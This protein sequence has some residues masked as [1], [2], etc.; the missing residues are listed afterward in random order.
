[1]TSLVNRLP[2][3]PDA[4][5]FKLF[6]LVLF[7]AVATPMVIWGVV[8]SYRL[9]PSALPGFQVQ[10]FDSTIVWAGTRALFV[11]GIS[12]YSPQGDAIVQTMNFGRPL[13]P[14]DEKYAHD[15][16]RFP[17]TSFARLLFL[18][19]CLTLPATYT[20]FQSRQPA[21]WVFFFLAATVLL[22]M[23]NTP[24]ADGMAGFCLAWSTIKPQSSILVIGY[25]VVVYYLAG[26]GLK[27]S[28]WFLAGFIGTGLLLLALTQLVSP[29]WVSEFIRSASDYRGYAGGLARKI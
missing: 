18:T 27:K 23:R 10:P 28:R 2:G 15:E 3:I 20:S 24:R 17:Q 29:G 21:V 11:Q 4:R 22:M 7:V 9:Y 6:A 25:V 12:P 5:W 16:Q 13:Q 26:H 1:M 19:F 8:S 14:G